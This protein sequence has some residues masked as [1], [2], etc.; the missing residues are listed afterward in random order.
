MSH[1]IKCTGGGGERRETGYVSALSATVLTLNPH[2][3]SLPSLH[4][5]STAPPPLPYSPRE[6]ISYLA[7]Y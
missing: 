5:F 1:M 7:Y 3:V 6:L 2:T 4:T